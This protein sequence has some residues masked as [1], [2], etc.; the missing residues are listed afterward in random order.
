MEYIPR[1]HQQIADHFLRQHDHAALFLEC[2][3]GKTSITMTVLHD[4]ILRDFRIDKALVI[5][6]KK[7]AE[8]TWSREAEKWD[9]LQDFRIAKIL[10]TEKQRRA[11]V[12][13]DADIYVINRENVQW[14]VENYGTKWKW[15]GLVIDELSSFK[16]PSAKRWRMLK[17]ILPMCK[18]VWGLTGTPA[19]NGYMDLYAEMYLID[20]G[21][22]L[23]KTLGA[24]RDTYFNPGAR[25]GH[26]VYEWKL[27]PGAKSRIDATLKDVCLSMTADDWLSLPDRIDLTD[28]VQMTPAERK[29]YEKFRQE[30]VLPLVDGLLA[31]SVEDAETAVVGITAASVSNKLLQMANGAVYDDA[32]GVFHI[33]DQKLDKLQ[34]IIEAANGEPVIVYYSYKH[35]LDRIRERFPEAQTLDD[36]PD[37]IRRWNEG[38]IPLLVCH[39]ASMG[40]GLNLQEGGHRMIW[41]G[42]PWSL[43][44]YQQACA[45]LLRPGQDKPVFIHHIVVDGTMDERVMEA[46]QRKDLSQAALMRAL[47]VYGGHTT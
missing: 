25:K 40:Y 6:P 7:V 42:V 5:A 45:R 23:G 36:A 11:A 29:V 22:R 28:H 1:K 38:Q 35:D 2:G 39:P 26:I 31:P 41:F 19:A 18:V 46:L 15:D 30:K 10:G 34:E 33:H 37:G 44:L 47:K 9:H 3:L 12:E 24:Y 32:G 14:L 21:K 13:S 4:Y 16:S 20:Q 43:E 8:D 27:K 17:R